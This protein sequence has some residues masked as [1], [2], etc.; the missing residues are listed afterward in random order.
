MRRVNWTILTT[1]LVAFHL[2]AVIGKGYGQDP[3]DLS[4]EELD[5]LRVSSGASLTQTKAGRAPASLTLITRQMIEESGARGLDELLEIY[6]PNF[7]RLRHEWS[8]DHI[9][10]RGTIS[11]LDNKSLL[12]VNGRTMNNRTHYGGVPERFLSQLGD[13]ASIEV[14]RGPGSAMYGPGAINGVINI[15]TFTPDASDE[16]EVSLANG[17]I[18]GFS[19]GEIRFGRTLGDAVD[20][21]LYYGIDHYNGASQGDSPLVYTKNSDIFTAGVPVDS[22]LVNDNRSMDGAP[23]HKAQVHV[24]YGDTVAWARYTRGSTSFVSARQ[25]NENRG[26]FDRSLVELLYDQVTFQA[27]QGIRLSNSVRLDLRV[28]Y[29]TNE[30]ARRGPNPVKSYTHAI[31]IREDELNVQ[32]TATWLPA[33]AHSIAAGVEYAHEWLGKDPARLSDDPAH[34]NKATHTPWGISSVGF[35]GEYQWN[36]GDRWTAFLG[37]RADNHSFTA[38]MYSPR[39]ALIF[40]ATP[41]HTSKMLAGRSVRRSEE[42]ELKAQHDANPDEDGET[43]T[44]DSFELIHSYRPANRFE[45]SVGAFFYRHAVTGWLQK[46]DR[47]APVGRL[48]VYGLEIESSRQTERHRTSASYALTKLHDFNLADENVKDQVITSAPYGYGNDLHNWPRHVGK[49]VWRWQPAPGLKTLVSLRTAWGYQGTRDYAD[50]NR[51]V[52]N[53]ASLTLTDGRTGAFEG[54]AFLNLGASCKVPAGAWVRLQFHNVLGW[55]QRDLNKRNYYARM[56]GYRDEAPAVSV[57]VSY[58]F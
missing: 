48:S 22:V 44:I 3:Y 32:S 35:F 43:E 7:T 51:E 53:Q 4:L 27:E 20:L 25:F 50:Y 29:D 12:L 33:P 55:I 1:F 26:S 37:G 19:R 2:A 24:R 23:R 15:R 47:Q 30:F 9:G 34:T 10:I 21:T 16:S 46:L 8:A 5:G 17:W 56:G 40:A 11:D 45:I 18:E 54:S 57:E 39:S 28:G 14:V 41:S 6:V 58:T 36:I 38:W 42:R 52:L 31:A 13:I 49:L